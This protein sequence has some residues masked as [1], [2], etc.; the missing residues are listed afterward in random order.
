MGLKLIKKHNPKITRVM[1][2]LYEN[3]RYLHV[4]LLPTFIYILEPLASAKISIYISK[5][6]KTLISQQ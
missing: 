6:E 2:Y 1:L 5:I 4:I 3:G